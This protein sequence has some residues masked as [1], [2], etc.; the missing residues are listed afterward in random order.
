[1][2]PIAPP[3]PQTSRWPRVIHGVVASSLLV[4]FVFVFLRC[5]SDVV[6]SQTF[7]PEPVAE[8]ES[9][10]YDERNDRSGPS[11]S[12]VDRDT[13]A[14]VEAQIYLVRGAKRALLGTAT[15]GE[16]QFADDLR[17]SAADELNIVPSDEYSGAMARCPIENGSLVYVRNRARI[18]NLEHNAK[19]LE[20][21]GN[22]AL[23]AFVY[24]EFAASDPAYAESMMPT[25]VGFVMLIKGNPLMFDGEP[26]DESGRLTTEFR[27]AIRAYQEQQSIE[28]VNGQLYYDTLSALAG[29]ASIARFVYTRLP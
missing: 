11:F 4:I 2:G 22:Y 8:G 29:G 24:H 13:D 10:Q 14:L 20:V 15:N 27:D 7:A 9:D 12:V 23:A 6:T 3:P 28:N 21:M 18:E 25:V 17:C 1:M 19:R 5:V 16:Y 26:L